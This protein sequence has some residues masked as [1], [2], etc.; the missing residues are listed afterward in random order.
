MSGGVDVGPAPVARSRGLLPQLLHHLRAR[1]DDLLAVLSSRLPRCAPGSSGKSGA[2][3]AIVGREISAA[4][5]RLQIG[6]EPDRHGPAAAAGGRLHVG[7]VDAVDIGPLFAVD[8]DAART[9]GSSVR[10]WLRS[11]TIRAPSHGTSGRWNSRWR[12]R[13]AC[14]RGALFRTPRRP[15]DTNPPD[16]ARAAAD[17]GFS[18]QPNGSCAWVT[19]IAIS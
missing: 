13:W 9:S 8:F 6:R 19:I 12:E 15:T 16:C 17:T 11:R 1:F 3:I 10:R 14:P 5:E 2:A 7:H 4:H 18:R